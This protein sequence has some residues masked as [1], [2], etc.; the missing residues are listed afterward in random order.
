[1]NLPSVPLQPAKIS[2][3]GALTY[4]MEQDPQGD[5]RLRISGLGPMPDFEDAV[6]QPWHAL[7]E[8]IT[9]VTMEDGITSVGDCNFQ[10]LPALTHVRLSAALKFV[11]T[12]SFRDCP[13]LKRSP[14]RRA[15][16]MWAAKHF[17]TTRH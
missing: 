7:A 8:R 4:S 9:S 10:E 15:L 17:S 13:S 11:G 16:R 12:F 1:M 6:S 3:T 14:F 2:E 5:L